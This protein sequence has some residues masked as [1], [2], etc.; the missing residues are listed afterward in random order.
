MA[1]ALEQTIYLMEKQNS[2]ANLFFVNIDCIYKALHDEEYCTILNTADLLLPDGIGVK[3]IT[4]IYG[5]R[6]REN[7][8]GSEFSPLLMSIAAKKNYKLFFLGGREGVAEKAAK[9]VLMN[10]QGI[11][12]TGTHSGYFDNDQKVIK[13]INDSGADIL[14]VAMGVPLQEKWIYHNR[15]DLNPKLCIGVGA[16]FDFLSGRIR[17]APKILRTLHLEW[18]WRLAIEPKRLWKRYLIDDMKF[19]GSVFIQKYIKKP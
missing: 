13:K 15:K 1:A 11:Q 3:M 12:I 19:M 2:K 7:C 16:L 18:C 6:M 9:Q 17:R 14:L 4:M 8:N 5:G 10:I